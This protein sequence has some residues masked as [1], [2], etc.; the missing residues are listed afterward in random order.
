[1][2]KMINIIL[3]VKQ[4]N[5]NVLYLLYQNNV[6]LTALDS[7]K[8]ENFIKN[9]EWIPGSVKVKQFVQMEN[10]TEFTQTGKSF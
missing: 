6:K 2:S 7:R 8:S 3:L 5:K 4:T 1:M 10:I 9:K